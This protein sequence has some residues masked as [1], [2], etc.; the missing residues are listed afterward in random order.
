MSLFLL[1]RSLTKAQIKKK[2]KKASLKLRHG[3]CFLELPEMPAKG[4]MTWRA[5]TLKAARK[6]RKVGATIY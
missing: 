1:W 6:T 2:K 3:K 4:L 5:V